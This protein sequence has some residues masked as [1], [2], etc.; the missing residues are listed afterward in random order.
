MYASALEG[1]E[2]MHIKYINYSDKEIFALYYRAINTIYYN[3]SFKSKMI[4]I[5][6]K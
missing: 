6:I 4:L 3:I 5:V 1:E 2:S